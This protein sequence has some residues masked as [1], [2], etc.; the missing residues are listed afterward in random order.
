MSY[1][2][3]GSRRLAAWVG[4]VVIDLP[5]AVGHPSFP[6]TLETL[7]A[8]NGG[9]TLDAARAAVEHPDARADFAVRRPRMLSPLVLAGDR[10]DDV[11]AHRA[12]IDLPQ[13]GQELVCRPELACIVGR[14]GLDLDPD[15]AADAL[16]G[17]TLVN[18]WHVR[19]RGELKPIGTAVGPCVATADEFDPSGRRCVVEV[20]GTAIA[21]VRLG[22]QA[23][24]RFAR[25]IARASRKGGVQP[26]E[27]FGLAPFAAPIVIAVP[28]RR[29]DDLV[30]AVDVPGIGRL[31]NR[32][33]ASR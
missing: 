33:A 14:A 25:T 1:D 32:V 28:R 21:E 30:I 6:A 29:R 7:V 13:K 8:R 9:T 4:D 3:G 20:D 19:A 23:P 12:V 16:F 2:R 22:A 17:Y 15:Q 24:A 31:E 5:D 18:G 10:A 27:L 11:M 26:G